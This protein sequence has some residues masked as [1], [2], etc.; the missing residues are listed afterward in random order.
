[1]RARLWYL[2]CWHAFLHESIDLLFDDAWFDV[3]FND[4]PAILTQERIMKQ[5]ASHAQ[6]A[7]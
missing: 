4:I 1:M 3:V 6:L 5:S 2:N 7:I